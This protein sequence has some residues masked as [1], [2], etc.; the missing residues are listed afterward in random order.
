[1][2]RRSSKS[3]G[4]KRNGRNAGSNATSDTPDTEE[5]TLDTSIGDDSISAESATG[6]DAPDD[7][8][9][10]SDT[11]EALDADEQGTV[12]DDTVMA[13]TDLPSDT[14]ADT[15]ETT[16]SIDEADTVIADPETPVIDPNEPIEAEAE[17]SAQ[18]QATSEPRRSGFVPLILGG[19]IA[20][21]IGYA[22]AFFGLAGGTQDDDALTATLN[23]QSETLATLQTQLSELASAEPEI[24][25]MPEVDFAP[26]LSQ[27]DALSGQISETGASIDTLAA[28]VTTL[29]ER[30]VFTGDVAADNAAAAE[31]V[32]QL[33]E[34]LRAQQEAAEAEAAALAAAAEE[35]EAEA[36]AAQQ[37]AA[38]AIAASQAAAAAD[39]AR[40][41]AEAALLDLN[42]AIDSGEPFTDA[43]QRVSDVADVP[44]ALSE[45][46]ET[47]VPT[48]E[49]LQQ[50]FGPAAR[51][52]LPIAL[53]E[54]AGDSVA[55]RA[56]AFL[57]G[58]VGGRAVTPREGTDPDA[59][60]SRVGA[61]VDSGDLQ[62]ALTEIGGLPEAARAELNP[63][64]SDVEKRASV[65]AA[66]ADVEAAIN[67]AN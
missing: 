60:L 14:G 65:L 15:D 5:S 21:G 22:V 13:D 41:A 10:A 1:M 49:A 67:S 28:R 63:W 66:L 58:Q 27:I 23:A 30:P 53:R 24:P 42:I 61:A 20:A 40:V 46:A 8:V 29:E 2:A 50:S 38:E 39:V 4:T 62:T 12:G 43:L 47:G 48:L 17:V 7:S 34:Q 59:V 3:S 51:D 31:A 26:V 16:A 33:E 18:P 11:P 57:L 35:A 64:V 6:S 9:T 32:T 54:T 37:E 52:V 25:E 56:T 45:N 44:A 55:D 36:E 19:V